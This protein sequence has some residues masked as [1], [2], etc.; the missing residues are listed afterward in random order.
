MK[1][2]IFIGKSGCGKTTLIQRLE[3]EE[4]RYRKTQMVEHYLHFIDTPGEY[5]ERR[6]MYRALIVSAVDAD[7]IGLVQECGADNSWL[8]PSFASS[9]AKPVFGV[10]SKVDLARDEREV[11]FAREILESAGVT[12]VFAV[13]AVEEIGLQPLLEYLN[14]GES[15]E[16]TEGT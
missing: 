16:G 4:L 11:Q 8:P 2:T 13:S 6:G 12:R 5:L 3:D 10:I 9:F 7:L 15:F 1:K 14:I